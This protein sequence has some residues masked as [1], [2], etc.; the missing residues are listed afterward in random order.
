MEEGPDHHE[1]VWWGCEQEVDHVV[2]VVEC[3]F[4]EGREEVLETRKR[5]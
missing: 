3:R 1:D 5:R 2:V 4:G